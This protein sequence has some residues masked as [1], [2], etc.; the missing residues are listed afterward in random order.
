M[1]IAQCRNVLL[2][3]VVIELLMWHM[4]RQCL[5]LYSEILA[6]RLDKSWTHHFQ[7]GLKKNSEMSTG[8]INC[9]KYP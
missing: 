7:L 3:S 1:Y 4:T 9:Y 2:C 8:L 6:T 5:D